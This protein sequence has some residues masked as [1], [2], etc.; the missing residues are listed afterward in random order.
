MPR[1]TM[2]TLSKRPGVGFMDAKLWDQLCPYTDIFVRK[3]LSSVGLI[4]FKDFK[5][6][7]SLA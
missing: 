1:V 4:G 7:F 3:F 2:C 6:I 5:D